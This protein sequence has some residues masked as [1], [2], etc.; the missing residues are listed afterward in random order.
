MVAGC[1]GVVVV[2]V[3][4]NDHTQPYNDPVTRREVAKRDPGAGGWGCGCI[5]IVWL[6]VVV[7]LWLCACGAVVIRLCVVVIPHEHNRNTSNHRVIIPTTDG[8]MRTRRS[9]AAGSASAGEGSAGGQAPEPRGQG[10]AGGQT[11]KPRG[12]VSAGGQTPGPSQPEPSGKG[13]RKEKD[14]EWKTA[15]NKVTFAELLDT[16]EEYLQ[17]ESDSP[18]GAS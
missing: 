8:F 3:R 15:K 17:D 5:E 7:V 14:G 9:I 4:Y 18:E 13:W 2:C 11:P 10:S 12:K 6:L 1:C 16:Y